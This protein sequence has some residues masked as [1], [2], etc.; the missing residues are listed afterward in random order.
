M[1]DK[2]RL[3][4]CFDES[5]S[6]KA[7]GHNY[8]IVYSKILPE[9]PKYLLEIGISND[10]TPGKTS[11]YAWKNFYPDTKIIG[12]DIIPDKLVNEDGISSYLLDQSDEKD[13]KKFANHFSHQFDVIVDDGSHIFKDARK[14]FEALFPLLSYNGV[15]IIEDIGKISSMHYK[16]NMEQWI[17]YLEGENIVHHFFDAKPEWEDDS[18]LLVIWKKDNLVV[19]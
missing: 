11:L 13:L 12:A 10:H 17:N 5:G 18:L 16:Q 7:S 1:I 3:E 14:T 19:R 4:F 8:H 6:D 2:N 15:F 9:N